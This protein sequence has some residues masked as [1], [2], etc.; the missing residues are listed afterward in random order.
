MNRF[1]SQRLRVAF[2]GPDVSEEALYSAFRPF[3]RIWDLSPPGAVAGT[4][5]RASRITFKTF[6]SSII[7][8]NVLYGYTVDGTRLRAF[9]EPPVNAH[10]L[11]D[12]ITNHP[13]LSIPLILFLF[14]TITL[15]VFDPVRTFLV[16][17]KMRDWLDYRKFGAY[18]WIRRNVPLGGG[19]DEAEE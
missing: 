3:G 16:E 9:Y 7:A 2:D 19:G 6:R 11:R 14:G 18:Q 13:R 1:P 15:A 4:P 17:A 8:R 10:A 5:Y 12:W